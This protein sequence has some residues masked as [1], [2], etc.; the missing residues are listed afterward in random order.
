MAEPITI[1]K[2]IQIGKF[3]VVL[4]E[5][6]RMKISE[7]PGKNEPKIVAVSINRIRATPITASAPNDSISDC[8]SSN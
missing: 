2:A 6:P 4:S 8:G 3:R 5:I 1:G 7:S